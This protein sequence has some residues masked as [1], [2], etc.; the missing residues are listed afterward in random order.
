MTDNSLEQYGITEPKKIHWNLSVPQLVEEAIRRGEAVLTSSGA[1]NALTVPRTGR[2][3]RDK[4]V[5]DY[6]SIHDEIWWG[7]VNVPMAVQTYRQL[8][9]E[10]LAHLRGRELFVVD[11]YLGADPRYQMPIRVITELAWHA[12]F[13]RQLFRRLPADRLTSH[14]P[15]WVLINAG[16][17]QPSA[18]KYNLNS[19]AA[20][21]LDFEG[22]TVLVTGSL[23]AGEMK[24]SMFTVLNYALPKQGVLTMH[25][26]A[27]VGKD[28]DTALFFGLSGTGKTTLSADTQRGLIGDDEHGWSDTGIFNLE[29]GCYA[30]CINLTKEREPLIW[31]AIR[32]G[33]VIE[34]VVVNPQTREPDYF[35]ASITENTRCA[36]PLDYI[37]NAIPG[38]MAGHPKAIL[39]L[40]SD[41]FGVLPAVA[42]L[43]PAQA[44]YH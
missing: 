40:A 2:S 33:A 10:A 18:K 31:D 8:R 29:G 21:V 28:G 32:F 43:N 25:C 30:K 34:N 13:A 41:A 42:R 4:W 17:F 19:D 24:K 26:S 5:V 44:M 22:K 14:K 37:A 6:P 27:N 38:G 36:Y 7:N 1:I 39:F 20:I 3:P 16:C 15:E 35:D 23:Y 9:A 12:L 11:A